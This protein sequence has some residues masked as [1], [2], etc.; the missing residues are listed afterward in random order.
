MRTGPRP[1]R[2]RRRWVRAHTQAHTG[3]H[4]HTHTHTRPTHR[5]DDQG[6]EPLGVGLVHEAGLGEDEA[7]GLPVVAAEDVLVEH[8]CWRRLVP[9]LPPRCWSSLLLLPLVLLRLLLRL[10]A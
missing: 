9:V 8:R 5:R 10:L 2:C 3:T 7:A 4:R 1:R 6:G